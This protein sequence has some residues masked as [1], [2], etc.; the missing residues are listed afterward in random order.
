[1]EQHRW[2]GDGVRIEEEADTF[3]SYLLMPMDDYRRQVAGCDIDLDLLRHVTDRYGVSLTAAIRKWIEFTEH[4]AAMVVGRDGFALWGRASDIAYRSGIFIRSGMPIPEDS[5]AARGP[6]A[7]RFEPNLPI[8]I[9]EGVWRFKRGSEPV[10]ELTIFADRLEITLTLLL[11]EP[12]PS[13]D[14]VAETRVADLFDGLQ[15]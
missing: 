1:M 6:E 9:P 5:V 13:W 4:R 10:R 8:Q 15:T 3:A 14:E 12:E 2:R 11:F 7:K